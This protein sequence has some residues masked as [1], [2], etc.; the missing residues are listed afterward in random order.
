MTPIHCHLCG[1]DEAAPFLARGGDPLTGGT[2]DLLRCRRCGLVFAARLPAVETLAQQYDESYYSEVLG[3]TLTEGN[4][5]SV[6][7]YF[8]RLLKE[9]EVHQPP[10]RLLD[11][12]CATGDFLAA[13]EKRGWVGAGLEVSPYAAEQARRRGLKVLTGSL[14]TV[15]GALD[16]YELVTLWEVIEHLPDPLGELRRIRPLL[17]PGGLL[18]VSTPNV[19]GISTRLFGRRSVTFKPGEHLFYFSRETLRQLLNAA[20]FRVVMARS[21]L[22]LV[23]NFLAALRRPPPAGGEAGGAVRLSPARK[24]LYSVLFGLLHGTGLGVFAVAC[25]NGLL[26]RL[27]LGDGLVVFAEAAE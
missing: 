9:I 13:A 25:A 11:L 18:A 12:G 19:Y 27:G 24:R 4:S 7:R 10:A 14:E 6:A 1:A 21:H 5:A 23:T 20:G 17:A 16:R 2:A 15:G 22:V 3:S 8:D 26:N